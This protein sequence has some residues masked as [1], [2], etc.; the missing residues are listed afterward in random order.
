MSCIKEIPQLKGDNYAEW[1]KKINLAFVCGEVDWVTT[2]PKP[3]EPPAL[4]SGTDETDADWQKSQRDY[5]A[6][7][8]SFD[9][10][11]AK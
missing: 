7:K 2:E 5:A 6:L 11:N 9:L 8:M 10:S 3:T 1:R 4:V